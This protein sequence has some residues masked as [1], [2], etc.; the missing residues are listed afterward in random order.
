MPK[1]P[2]TKGKWQN[3]KMFLT[4]ITKGYRLIFLAYKEYIQIIKNRWFSQWEDEQKK[5]YKWPLIT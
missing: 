5:R 4:Y 1:M 2:A 3:K